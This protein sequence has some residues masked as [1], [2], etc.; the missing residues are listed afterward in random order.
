[1]LM[2][3]FLALIIALFGL[4]FMVKWLFVAAIVAA[5]LWVIGFFTRSPEARWYRW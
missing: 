2:I 3:L 1:M 5:L 4:G